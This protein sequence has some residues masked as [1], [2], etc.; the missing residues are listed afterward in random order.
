MKRFF[1]LALSILFVLGLG[2]Q[3]Y[4]IHAEIPAETQAAVA[5][6]QTQITLGGSIRVRGEYRDNLDFN[7]DVKDHFSAYDE[8]IRLSTDAKLSENLEGLVELELTNG[9][10]AT[11]YT[12]GSPDTGA[13]GVYQQGNAKR[14]E[15]NLLQGWIQW[16]P[17]LVGVKIGHMPLYLGNKLFFDH[18]LF[19]DDAIV[20]FKGMDN[21]HLTLLDAKFNEGGASNDADAYVLVG[22]YNSEMFNASLDVTWVHDNTG[23]LNVLGVLPV[24]NDVTDLYNIGLR[25]DTTVGPAKLRADVEFQTGSVQDI[26]GT[27]TDID[28]GGWAY[29][30]GANM[31]LQ[32]VNL[33]VEWAQGSGIDPDDDP[34]EFNMFVTSLSPTKYFAYVYD[35]RA[36][37][38]A[39]VTHSGIANTS[40]LK[41]EGNTDLT[42]ALN[43]DLALIWLRATEKV[44]LNGGPNAENDL[45]WEVDWKGTYKLARNLNYWVEGGYLITGDA[46]QLA[47]GS[48]A[49]NAYALRHGVQLSF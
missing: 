27:E 12:W 10:T 41:V 13:K 35:Y 16:T 47:D 2:V 29:M 3:A 19:G 5:V 9:P 21:I 48:D 28:F 11:T 30:V 4:A 24:Q 7:D 14:G 6:G 18:S 25:G 32:N 37:T 46:Y 34:D 20:L 23:T 1:V 26:F 15:L 43:L 49:D 17:E 36:V 38:A 22:A 40:Y 33:D 45:G 8:R 44:A 39:G 42:D 31:D